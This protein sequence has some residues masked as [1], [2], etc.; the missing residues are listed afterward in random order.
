MRILL[1]LVVILLAV[2]GGAAEQTLVLVDGTRM[3]IQSY[4]VKGGVVQFTTADGK[5]RSVPRSYVDLAATEQANRGAT[6]PEPEPETK[7][8][9]APAPEPAPP[10]KPETKAEPV[11]EPEPAPELPSEPVAPE[12]PL[13]APSPPPPSESSPV[14]A[15]A[16]MELGASPPPAWSN[17]ELEVSLQVPSAAWEVEAMPPSFDVAVAMENDAT[18]AR[19]TLAL[20]RRKIRGRKDF[21]EVVQE[22]EASI[23]SAP[24]YQPLSNGELRL[25]PYAAHEFRFTKNVGPV[26]V[27][28][29]LI[30]VYSRDL[31]YVLSL[32][33][34]ENRRQENEAD[35]EALARGL[36]I[37]KSRSELTF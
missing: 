17:A 14:K 8:E 33:C 28:N 2:F 18:E 1:S 19:A 22:I 21:Q 26:N 16:H 35:F 31:A 27:Y 5:L 6:A 34:P 25:D 36:V 10:P 15:S 30:V 37:R 12:P 20:I 13:A 9:P 4:E 23:S 24:G 3:A 11:A 7:P 32:T 29:R